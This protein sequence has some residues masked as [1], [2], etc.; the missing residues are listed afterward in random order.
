MS[1]Q[2][3]VFDRTA[4]GLVLLDHHFESF[5][6][7]QPYADATKHPVPMDTR[8]WSQILVSVLTGI[9]GVERKKGAD[10]ADGSDVKG[11]NTW[12]AIDTPRFNGVFKA[13]TKAQS[14]GSIQSLRS[15]PFLFFVL[16]D[17][18]VR[19]THRCR[20]WVVRTQHDE[21]FI[22]MCKSWYDKAMDG[23]IRSNNFQL[24]PPRMKDLDEIRNK[25]GNLIYPL[26][27]AAE[28]PS[29]G[30]G[31]AVT[32]FDPSVLVEGRCRRSG[33]EPGS[34]GGLVDLGIAGDLVAQDSEE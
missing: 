15:M 33:S 27:F 24:H 28:R 30:G 8:G 9:L 7:V 20:V 5:Y 34:A 3:L 14:S 26:Y 25:C 6:S 19:E 12:E 1:S 11:A 31:Y 17:T 23:T 2:P 21:E 4:E 22:S 16:W 18:T 29:S 10:L 13:G 32:C